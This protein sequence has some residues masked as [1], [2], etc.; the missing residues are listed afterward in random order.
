[1]INKS[2]SFFFFTLLAV[3][4]VSQGKAALNANLSTRCLHD[5]FY[6]PVFENCTKICQPGYYGDFS[7]GTCSV[8]D[9]TCYSCTGPSKLQ[10]VECRAPYSYRFQNSSGI[11]C[12]SACSD[13]NAS[14]YEYLGSVCGKCGESSHFV[15]SLLGTDTC[16]D[17]QGGGCPYDTTSNMF[18]YQTP[19]ECL[20]ASSDN[21]SSCTGCTEG[22]TMLPI[23]R[24]L[25]GVTYGQC[26]TKLAQQRYNLPITL[27][28][29]VD[30]YVYC[31]AN[32]TTCTA[33]R[34]CLTCSNGKKSFGGYCILDACPTDTTQNQDS[35]DC[36]AGYFAD[37]SII[38]QFY[39]FFLNLLSS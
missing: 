17:S 19:A 21:K 10:C 20:W 26:H 35:C 2:A 7:T 37:P 11:S 4:L 31:Q 9:P 27:D 12:L 8:C 13:A 30:S 6:D 24:D 1:M 39:N 32:C 33:N 3:C 23:S 15:D 18:C 36:P 5:Y 14:Y 16:V 25:A 38:L 28:S 29:S 34:T 22:Y